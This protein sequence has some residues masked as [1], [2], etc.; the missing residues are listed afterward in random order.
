M[1]FSKHK[2]AIFI[3]I[4]KTA[5]TS[6]TH[7]FQNRR[8]FV[9]EGRQY[10][11]G[12]IP[13]PQRT[14]YQAAN[15]QHIS[16]LKIIE[17]FGEEIWRRS[18]K[19]TVVRNP[20]DRLVSFYEYSRIARKNINSVQWG[21]PDPGTFEEWLSKEKPLGQLHYLTDTNGKILV[22]YIAKLE[23]L[24]K[25][26]LYICFKLK[27]LPFILPKLNRSKRR[28]YQTYYN[29]QIKGIVDRYY[30]NEIERFGYTF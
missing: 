28:P 19:F 14:E 10:L 3:W 9:R 8:I 21:K 27:V 7:K 20:Y 24:Q 2:K 5:G 18:F 1:P 11:W 26:L 16:S 30:G 15:W 22:D 4:P 23:T 17:E 13:E 25:D 6:L 29:P 12:R